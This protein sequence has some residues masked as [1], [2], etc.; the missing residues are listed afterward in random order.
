MRRH[1]REITLLLF[2]TVYL[3]GVGLI[4]PDFLTPSNLKD[5]LLNSACTAI[6]GVGMTLVILIGAIDISI[7]SLLAVS[8]ITAG[9]LARLGLPMPAVA[10]VTVAVGGG[11]GALNGLGVAWARIPPVL[12]TLGMMSLLRGALLWITKGVWI[13]DLPPA[14]LAWGQERWLGLPV[15]VLVMGLVVGGF[16]WGLDALPA[17]RSLYAVGSNPAAARLAGIPVRT[18]VFW[19]FTVQGALVGLA[20]LTYA[21]RFS[22]I[23][24]NAGQGFELWVITA[25]VIG[26]TRILGGSGTVLG[27]LLGVLLLAT[28]STSLTFL[29][30]PAVWEPATQGTLILLAVL[31]DRVRTRR[32]RTARRIP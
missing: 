29:R 32:E 13:Q 25:V 8:A 6:A 22:A 3:L 15:P 23:Q 30:V 9:H 16:A 20:T 19:V 12:M 1:P 24:S 18:V 26:G 11:L 17:G 31:A 21:T 4:R 28:I 2:L 14:F 7:G 5:I 27:T 10:L